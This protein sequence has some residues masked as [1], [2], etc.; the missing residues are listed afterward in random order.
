MKKNWLAVLILLGFVVYGAYDYWQGRQAAELAAEQESEKSAGGAYETGIQLGQQAPDF[1]LDDLD[2]NPYS[3][4]ELRGKVVFVNFWATWCPPCR[5]EMPHMQ[6]VYE[7]HGGD[8]VILGVNMTPSE[9]SQ[10]TVR[11]FI[12]DQSLSF[13]IVLDEEGQVK[14]RYRVIS[15]PTTYVLD[16]DG[17]IR[18]IY[19]GPVNT[20]MM[21]N[22]IRD[23]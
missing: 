12:Q 10:E 9:S 18:Q 17:I 21:N 1:Q 5:V 16:Q 20:E 4:S 2:G 11:S 19:R 3:L 7:E 14:D 22:T 13:P 8:V 6:Q 15:Y 23:M